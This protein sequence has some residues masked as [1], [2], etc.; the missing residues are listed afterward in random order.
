M[1]PA[2]LQ[3]LPSQRTRPFSPPIFHF[4]RFSFLYYYFFL[5]VCPRTNEKLCIRQMQ[6]IIA[7]KMGVGRWGWIEEDE[8]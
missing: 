6:T 5:F 3:M 7:P 1:P 2:R 4:V 8:S